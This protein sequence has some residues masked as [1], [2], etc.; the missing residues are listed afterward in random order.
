METE[1]TQ[2]L[3]STSKKPSTVPYTL[4]VTSNQLHLSSYTTPI[5]GL[6]ERGERG[7][8]SSLNWYA[9]QASFSRLPAESNSS[10]LFLVPLWSSENRWCRDNHRGSDWKG[11]QTSTRGPTASLDEGKFRW[12]KSSHVIRTARFN[13]WALGEGQT[14]AWFKASPDCSVPWSKEKCLSPHKNLNTDTKWSE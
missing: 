4:E 13:Q 14:P 10:F 12:R 3:S 1:F 8:V 2:Y 6:W 7:G 11:P 9:F 5:R